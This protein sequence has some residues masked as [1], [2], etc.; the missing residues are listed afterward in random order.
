[1]SDGGR[2]PCVRGYKAGPGHATV[3]SVV[4]DASEHSVTGLAGVN[5]PSGMFTGVSPMLDLLTS[6]VER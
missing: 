2:V 1:M 5:M 3:A 4:R 6:L